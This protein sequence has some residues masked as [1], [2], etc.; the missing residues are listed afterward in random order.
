V[1]NG[2]PP[3]RYAPPLCSHVSAGYAQLTRHVA[4]HATQAAPV[5]PSALPSTSAPS[6][7]PS[8]S[9]P[10]AS[11]SARRLRQPGV[12]G[13]PSPDSAKGMEPSPPTK[14]RVTSNESLQRP[15]LPH[16]V[17][18]SRGALLA[19]SALLTWCA[20]HAVRRWPSQLRCRGLR[21]LPEPCRVLLATCAVLNSSRAQLRLPFRRRRP[22]SALQRRGGCVLSL[23]PQPSS[24]SQ[25]PRASWARRPALQPI[26]SAPHRS[27]ACHRRRRYKRGLGRARSRRGRSLIR[28]GQV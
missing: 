4:A 17:R 24:T 16:A 28:S 19:C 6:T 14:R 15:T 18:C 5:G 22:Q 2:S 9:T 13:K 7:L 26:H 27:R 23:M 8:T 11:P 21:L 1:R 25:H 10:V 20:A 12:A 3:Q